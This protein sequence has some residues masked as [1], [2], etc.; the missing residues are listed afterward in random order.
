MNFNCAKRLVDLVNNYLDVQYPLES[1]IISPFQENKIYDRYTWQGYAFSW[2]YFPWE[3]SKQLKKV[4]KLFV[5]SIDTL[6]CSSPQSLS[7][8]SFKL[9]EIYKTCKQ[10]IPGEANAAAFSLFP[11]TSEVAEFK[12]LQ[13]EQNNQAQQLLT[14]NSLLQAKNEELVLQTLDLTTF[15]RLLNGE[16]GENLSLVLDYWQQFLAR[17]PD[18]TTVKWEEQLTLLRQAIHEDEQI[19]NK[20]LSKEVNI[21]EEQREI[22]RQQVSCQLVEA[23]KG[24]DQTKNEKKLLFFSYGNPNPSVSS[25]LARLK[26]LPTEL[27]NQLPPPLKKMIE[28]GT[29]PDVEQLAKQLITFCEQKVE[30]EIGSLDDSIEESSPIKALFKDEERRLPAIVTAC[31][32][33]IIDSYLHQVLQA[34]VIGNTEHFFEDPSIKAG[35]RWLAEHGTHLLTEA[36]RQPLVKLVESQLTDYIHQVL[37]SHQAALQTSFSQ[38]LKKIQTVLPHE[39]V[40]LA[41]LNSLFSSGPCW[42]AFEKQQDGLYSLTVYTLGEGLTYHP[43][44]SQTGQP[45][46]CLRLKDIE[47]KE[48]NEKFFS[49]LLFRRFEPT[50]NYNYVSSA[51]DFY[52][53]PLQ[54]LNAK[55]EANFADDVQIIDKFPSSSYDLMQNLLFQAKSNTIDPILEMRLE[56]LLSF[57]QPFLKGEKRTLIIPNQA[58]ADSLRSAINQLKE[59][60]T[61]KQFNHNQAKIGQLKATFKE[62]EQ[63]LTGFEQQAEKKEELEISTLLTEEGQRAFLRPIL[64]K[65]GLT[66]QTIAS[67]RDTMSWLLGQEGEEVFDTFVS[68]YSTLFDSLPETNSQSLITKQDLANK[69]SLQANQGYLKD[70]YLGIYWQIAE[71]VIKL[72]LFAMG[73]YA[74]GLWNLLSLPLMIAL[75]PYILPPSVLDFYQ[76]VMQAV[77]FQLAKGAI[78]LLEKI[79]IKGSGSP[80]LKE[81][82]ARI[83]QKI[84]EIPQKLVQ[85]TLLTY[86]LV[87]PMPAH[88]SQATTLMDERTQS[89]PLFSLSR[90]EVPS[91][92]HFSQYAPAPSSLSFSHYSSIDAQPLVE[93]KESLLELLANPKYLMPHDYCLHIAQHI[94]TLATP[95]LPTQGNTIWDHLEKPAEYVPLLAEIGWKLTEA[96]IKC[97]ELGLTDQNQLNSKLTCQHHQFQ[98]FLAMH[99]LQAIL[100]CLAKQCEEVALPADSRINALNLINLYQN[101]YIMIDDPFLVECLRSLC[102]YLLPGLDIEKRMSTKDLEKE[103]EQ[104][105]FHYAIK[106]NL[107]NKLSSFLKKPEKKLTFLDYFEQGRI[108]FLTDIMADE[109]PLMESL[110]NVVPAISDPELHY[111]EKRMQDKRSASYFEELGIST[112]FTNYD[113]QAILFQ[114]SFISSRPNPLISPI[115]SFLKWHTLLCQTPFLSVKATILLKNPYQIIGP[116]Y[117]KLALLEKETDS[118]TRKIKNKVLFK[119]QTASFK[120]LRDIIGIFNKSLQPNFYGFYFSSPFARNLGFKRTEAK[121]LAEPYKTDFFPDYFNLEIGMKEKSRRIN[122]IIAYLSR[123]KKIIY[124]SKNPFYLVNSLDVVLFTPGALTDYLTD[125]PQAAKALGEIVKELMTFYQKQPEGEN[126]Y[127]WSVD[128]GIRLRRYCTFYMA[129]THSFFPDFTKELQTCPLA[130]DEEQRIHIAQLYALSFGLPTSSSPLNRQE[131]IEAYL[132]ASF[133]QCRIEEKSKRTIQLQVLKEKYKDELTF[134]KSFISRLEKLQE[135]QKQLGEH[136]RIDFSSQIEDKN[137]IELKIAE[138]DHWLNKKPQLFIAERFS[139]AYALWQTVLLEI[140]KD[141]TQCQSFLNNLAQ[142]RGVLIDSSTGEVWREEKESYFT[143][144]KI[145]ICFKTSTISQIEKIEDRQKLIPIDK[146]YLKNFK[147]PLKIFGQNLEK[148]FFCQEGLWETADKRYAVCIE[149]EEKDILIFQTFKNTLY[150]LVAPDSYKHKKFNKEILTKIEVESIKESYIW[151]KMDNSSSI[152]QLLLQNRT[153]LEKV[154]EVS[155]DFEKPDALFSPNLAKSCTT[156]VKFVKT[157]PYAQLPKELASLARFCPLNQLTATALAGESFLDSFCLTPRKLNFDVRVLK[158]NKRVALSTE[159][160]NFYLAENQEHSAVKGIASY[161]ILENEAGRKKILISKEQWLT[162]LFSRFLWLT[163]PLERKI[164]DELAINN[165]SLNAEYHIM[166]VGEEVELPSHLDSQDPE[167]IAYLLLLYMT[168]GRRALVEKFCQRLVWCCDNQKIENKVEKILSLLIFLPLE[169]EGISA[170]RRQLFAALEKNYQLYPQENEMDAV[171]ESTYQQGISAGILLYDLTQQIQSP[172]PRQT[173][174]ASQEFFLFKRLFRCIG[175]L[176]YQQVGRDYV[177][178]DFIHELGWD[179]VIEMTGLLPQLITRYKELKKK[180][181]IQETG[182][183]Q[184]IKLLTDI[185]HTPSGITTSPLTKTY[186]GYADQQDNNVINL[187]MQLGKLYRENKCTNEKMLNLTRLY[188]QMRG[189]VEELSLEDLN[190]G[191][192]EKLFFS[193]ASYYALARGDVIS[194]SVNHAT[195]EQFNR[196]LKLNKGGWED[197][198]R[199]L[200]TYLEAIATYPSAFP[201]TNELVKLCQTLKDLPENSIEQIKSFKDWEAFFKKINDQIFKSYFLSQIIEPLYQ[202]LFMEMA[203]NPLLTE[204]CQHLIPPQLLTDYTVMQLVQPIAQ[205]GATTVAQVLKESIKPLGHYLP[206]V[207]VNLI[208][209]KITPGTVAKCAGTVA[210]SFAAVATVHYGLSNLT[211][212]SDQAVCQVTDSFLPAA[213]C[214]AAR[215]S[216]L[217]ASLGIGMIAK[218]A[219]YMWRKQRNQPAA[220]QQV[221]PVPEVTIPSLQLISKSY[222][223]LIKNVFIEQILEVEQKVNK[224]V[225]ID[226]T[227]LQEDNQKIDQI[228]DQLF[229]KAFTKESITQEPN[230]IRVPLFAAQ[231][232]DKAITKERF[233]RVNESI[234]QYYHLRETLVHYHLEKPENFLSIYVHLKQFY[235]SFNQHVITEKEQLTAVFNSTPQGKRIGSRKLTFAELYSYVERGTLG[236]LGQESG[237]HDSIIPQL[238]LAIAR[239]NLKT[240]RLQ[241]VERLIKLMEALAPLTFQGSPQK[242][243]ELVENLAMEL[244]TRLAFSLETTPDRLTWLNLQFQAVSGNLLWKRQAENRRKILYDYTGDLITEEPPGDGKSH[245]GIPLTAIHEADG[246]KLAITIVPKQLAGDNQPKISQQLRKIFNKNSHVQSFQRGK[247]LD[248]S[249]LETLLVLMSSARREG[250]VIQ[251]TKEDIQTLKAL[252]DDRLY[253]YFNQADW[254]DL[255]EKKCLGLLHK[256]LQLIHT[257]GVGIIDEVHDINRHDQ[258]LNFTI[259]SSHTIQPEFYMIMEATARALIEDPDIAP[260]AKANKLYKINK[261]YYESSIKPRLAQVMSHYWRFNITDEFKRQE[262]IAFVCDKGPIPAWIQENNLMYQQTSLVKGILYILFPMNLKNVANVNY[263]ASQKGNGNFARPSDG[264]SHVIESNSIQN[265]YETV[266]KTFLMLFT[267]GLDQRQFSQL[268]SI[269]KSKAQREMSQQN[270]SF[271]KTK[272]YRKFGS[273]FSQNLILVGQTHPNFQTAYQ[274]FCSDTTICLFYSRF[275]VWKQIRYWK[276]SIQITAQDFSTF[277]HRQLS[278]TGTPYNDGTYP[279]WMQM[280]RDPTTIG[281]LLHIIHQKCPAEGIHLLETKEPLAILAEVLTRFFITGKKFSAIIDGGAQFTGLSNEQ[282]A[283]K[284]IEHCTAYRPDIKAVKFYKEDETGK[285]Q[286]YCLTKNNPQPILAEHLSF[287]PSECLTYY[288]QRHG[289]GADIKQ[290]GDGLELM[291]PHH[292]LYRWLQEVF[293]I[294]GLKK[295]QRLYRIEQQLL[296]IPQ[297][298]IHFCLTKDVQKMIMGMS[299]E[300]QDVPVPKL[301][302]LIDYAIRQEAAIAESENYDA[303]RRKILMVVKKAIY[304]KIMERP[305]EKFSEWTAMWK[306]FEH[307]FITE[308]EDDPAKLF[309][310]IKSEESPELVLKIAVEKAYGL[311][312]KSPT[313]TLEEKEQ[314]R[315]ELIE[316]HQPVMPEK[317]TAWHNPDHSFNLTALDGM[318]LTQTVEASQEQTAEIEQEQ[319]QEVEN[320]QEMQNQQR[321]TQQQLKEKFHY[322]EWSWPQIEDLGSL[323]WLQ[324]SDPTKKIVKRA[325]WNMFSKEVSLPFFKVTDILAK[326]ER[327]IM[328]KVAKHFDNR[329]WFSNN[330]LPRYGKSAKNSAIDIGSPYQFKL[331]EVLVHFKEEA[332]GEKQILAM[333]P[334]STRDA[335]FWRKK[336]N[337]AP[338]FWVDQE[339]KTVLWDVST[340][341]IQAGYPFDQTQLREQADFNLL[342]GQLKLL[343]G[344]VQLKTEKPQLKSWFNSL[345]AREMKLACEEIYNQ[346]AKDRYKGSSAEDLFL[347]AIPAEM[348]EEAL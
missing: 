172:D 261:E 148:L 106:P 176:V 246:Q 305:S 307:L 308:V 121:A 120:Y 186:S 348:Y 114:E 20:L 126:L 77:K 207:G 53:G 44:N 131:A 171:D 235:H 174:S 295:Q 109:D 263:M 236:G 320:Q 313:F 300:E 65:M 17:H 343:D 285:E 333:G 72:V 9:A 270:I 214:L 83:Q 31:L 95:K 242:Y 164:L 287:D 98:Y 239:L 115:F 188:Q 55:I 289:F 137:K 299:Q 30:Q 312:A 26:L 265:P 198:S 199:L 130:F 346:R 259:G 97:D 74:G 264:N 286:I 168:Q 267:Q 297:Q 80:H 162:T 133:N 112:S 294:R 90:N 49:N 298:H 122:H 336:L 60:L 227:S 278:C 260:Y 220:W 79:I 96:Y 258:Q 132:A 212:D 330:F 12:R 344:E 35:I 7:T 111:L 105:F 13:T 279:A 62:I 3:K 41:G 195:P 340:R 335:A 175:L 339:V 108:K 282:V 255:E 73:I 136:N 36:D 240:A 324:F 268:L 117:R 89:T 193:F 216:Q 232:K 24:L 196:F 292:P 325:F 185:V 197:Q 341:T 276:K 64:S 128:L 189:R 245:Y 218:T 318:D 11:A 40:E 18:Y 37:T 266:I 244:Q 76:R 322:E 273:F 63:A 135:V 326:D 271:K 222:Q 66:K 179:T 149:E 127:L 254:I 123:N 2:L 22:D 52:Q 38:Q 16:Q 6:H 296:D 5:E 161:L 217:S 144:G 204:F 288:D 275:F 170:V 277:F 153:H 311:I 190:Q 141:P 34:G 338:E 180:A 329:L 290:T 159:F 145:A 57:C 94:L 229:E 87:E 241:Q 178:L 68:S 182:T 211:A 201:A 61:K 102:A 293:R 45:Y 8:Y 119:N 142:K 323:N 29:L 215:T 43:K 157:V 146:S 10:K 129:T 15:N 166:T 206:Q 332:T 301:A 230:E 1:I 70:Y 328:K 202:K 194:D 32:P 99:Q 163:G 274:D 75:L 150:G 213:V 306:E 116:D 155:F 291:G 219:R 91:F 124:Q 33:T 100:F 304:K 203:V 59:R 28:A 226:F 81:K 152:E 252:F 104:T 58:T 303:M 25:L 86:Q 143:Q 184:V 139:Q 118:L 78:K 177:A 14:Q 191:S 234:E 331:V 257:E 337:L 56:W 42:T 39:L 233:K 69:S 281:E 284:M 140:L 251:M 231:E 256:I 205:V 84:K 243:Q 165:S 103:A 125:S 228:L 200:M 249:N 151:K 85:P 181:G 253:R 237:L 283:Q 342:I 327:K 54:S 223:A 138:I 48:L 67:L 46:C 158:S 209:K 187:C 347:T 147:L 19:C 269:L 272:I 134:L 334:V 225:T 27:M 210:L 309:G 173:L 156:D 238:A 321:L 310:L 47:E 221:M 208:G 315:Q 183:S 110:L 316:L 167:V 23:I 107:I 248:Y 4:E 169:I 154:V 88:N 280:L 192:A 93:P 247:K 160:P 82:W 51:R 50:F 224:R 345:N 21:T 101:D 314:I 262:F 71:K 302:D 113:K 92:Q 250:E 319:K 317:V